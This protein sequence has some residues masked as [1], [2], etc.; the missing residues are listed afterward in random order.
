MKR[1]YANGIVPAGLVLFHSKVNEIVFSRRCHC[2]QIKKRD[3][4]TNDYRVVY[5]VHRLKRYIDSFISA[6]YHRLTLLLQAP[7]QDQVVRAL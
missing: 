1:Q 3:N 6:H 7:Q 2:E 4:Q 5:T